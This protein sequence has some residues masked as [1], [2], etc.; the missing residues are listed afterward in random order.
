MDHAEPQ[1]TRTG[2]VTRLLGVIRALGPAGPLLVFATAGPIVGLLALAATS[3][4]WLAWFGE[5]PGAVA[6]AS[7]WLGG[8]VLTAL[9]LLPT[10]ATSLLAGYLFGTMLGG[11]LGL[12][13]VLLGAVLGFAL[14]T[15]LVGDHVLTAVAASPRAASVHRALLGRGFGR[16]VWLVALLRLSPV[17][18]FA[19]TNLLMASLGVRAWPF[20]CATALGVAPRA[21]GAALVGAELAALDWEA[22]GG[23]WSHVLAIVAT[24]AVL[25]VVGLT[26][27]RALRDEVGAGRGAV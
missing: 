10:H 25:V 11:A 19:A 12:L 23:A 15:R 17:M 21:V 2:P 26:A 6:A 5:A 24:V 8:A 9:C 22:G 20:L 16:T 4:T 18:P 13:V 3:A 7:F 1:R 14:S 27:R